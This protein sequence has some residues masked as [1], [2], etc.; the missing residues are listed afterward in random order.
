MVTRWVE[1][2]RYRVTDH[3]ILYR[4]LERRIDVFEN[5]FANRGDRFLAIRG[6]FLD[7]LVHRR[8]IGL[9][10]VPPFV[11]GIKDRLHR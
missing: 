10:T 2:M 5:D 7:V 6:K 11:N 4:L 8:R 1:G 9:H 3:P